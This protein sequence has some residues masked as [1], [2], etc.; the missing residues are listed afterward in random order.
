MLRFANKS[1]M[2]HL[3]LLKKSA[4]NADVTKKSSKYDGLLEA[5]QSRRT[6]FSK[7]SG[8]PEVGVSI[9]VGIRSDEATRDEVETAETGAVG[10]VY[11]EA[12]FDDEPY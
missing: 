5:A 2:D 4:S 11:I 10:G 7:G 6:D 1:Y 12:P 8:R 3:T 9:Q